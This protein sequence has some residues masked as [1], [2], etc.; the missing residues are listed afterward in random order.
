MPDDTAADLVILTAAPGDGMPDDPARVVILEPRAASARALVQ[1]HPDATVIAA[2]LAGRVGRASLTSWNLPGLRSLRAPLAALHALFPGL[3][4]TAREEV[5]CIDLPGL[6]ARTGPWPDRVALHLDA[7]GEEAAILEALAASDALDR[8]CALT[9]RCGAEPFFEGGE[10]AQ[11]LADRLDRAGLRAVA[12]DDSDPD[13]PVL[14]FVRDPAR[15]ALRARAETAEAR[16]ADLEDR[17]KAARDHAA[18]LQERI[19]AAEART[20]ELGDGLKAA[21]DR[22]TALQARLEAAEARAADLEAERLGAETAANAAKTR[23][24]GLQSRLDEVG[25]QLAALQADAAAR[26]EAEAARA[27]AEAAL[28]QATGTA[29]RAREDL[30]LALRMQDLLQGDLEA[31]RA[32][33]AEAEAAR[34][35]Q[36]ALLAELAPRL[37]QAAQELGLTETAPALAEPPAEAAPEALPGTA[38]ATQARLTGARRK[39]GKKKDRKARRE[40]AQ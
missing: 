29:E 19:E 11:A 23:A 36:A 38:D 28:A 37:R 13:W 40:A 7:P 39:S 3:R 17:L 33:Y 5:D 34:A 4:E 10:G 9:L 18:A 20:A 2:A 31:M 21:Q 16:A 27:R 8:L 22:E 26:A 30:G 15:A 25:G 6:L 32:R 35:R 14:R 1:A 12:R 24:A